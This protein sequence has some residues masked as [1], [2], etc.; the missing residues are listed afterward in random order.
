VA[1]SPSVLAKEAGSSTPARRRARRRPSATHLVIGAVAIL[2]FV[3]NLLALRDRDATVMVAVAARPLAV[4]TVLSPDAVRLVPAAADF[5]G[6]P[7]L[8]AEA[9]LPTVEGWVLGRSVPSGG[10][11]ER[12]MLVEPGAP[13]GL[14]SMSI[15]VAAEHAAGGSIGPGDRVD[16][17]SVE[18][19]AAAY[20]AVG[21]E[22][23]AASERQGGSLGGLG[24]FYIVVA[25]DQEQ[26]LR[27]AEAIDGGSLEVVR[28]TGA[29]EID[30]GSGGDGS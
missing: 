27:L 6:L 1:V 14:R 7:S 22:V 16:I 4:G 13:S 18:D 10:L 11:I 19:G 17:I 12:T 30:R 9:Q 8:V 20:V 24:T 15:P 28:S 29:A 23:L 5:E 21:L 2:A 25:V 26:A 3:L